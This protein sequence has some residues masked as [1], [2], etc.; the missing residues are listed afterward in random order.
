[1]PHHASVATTPVRRPAAFRRHRATIVPMHRSVVGSALRVMATLLAG[2]RTVP[3]AT[4]TS[5]GVVVESD[6][7]FVSAGRRIGVE[8]F[9]PAGRGRHAGVLVLH[10]SA[11]LRMWAGD[12][13]RDYAR[14]L[15]R[16][17]LVAYVVHY[18]D[19]TGDTHTDA[20]EEDA[21]FPV[22]TATLQDAIT[23]AE[24]DSAVR[25]AQIGVLG[26][27]LGGFMALAVAAVDDR[28]RAIA[29]ILGVRAASSMRCAGM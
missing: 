9:A 29:V 12:G 2:C 24:R 25:R 6:T 13:M 22:W 23:F 14:A 15:A 3:S 10:S 21:K 28:V 16:A 26:V 1:M 8:R 11:G 17:G 5:P 18:F 27:S 4:V 20:A 7:A 19:R